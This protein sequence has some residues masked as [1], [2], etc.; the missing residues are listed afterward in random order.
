[1]DFIDPLKSFTEKEFKALAL[2]EMLEDA[3]WVDGMEMQLDGKTQ[4]LYGDTHGKTVDEVVERWKSW[5]KVAIEDPT[6]AE[7]KHCG[8]CT[9]VPTTCFRCMCEEKMEKIRKL[10]KVLETL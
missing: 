8:D 7:G 10:I 1:M 2:E 4:I 3:L 5:F 9:H 6:W